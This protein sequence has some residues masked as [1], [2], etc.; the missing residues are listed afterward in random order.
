MLGL[1]VVVVGCVLG[2]ICTHAGT[3]LASLPAMLPD[4]N[5]MLCGIACG[6]MSM[7]CCVFG[8]LVCAGW[9]D[10]VMGT[11]LPGILGCAVLLLAWLL[12]L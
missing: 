9:M 1:V 2:L 8:V 7:G 5:S 6:L 12:G 3:S 4:G 10:G 11:V